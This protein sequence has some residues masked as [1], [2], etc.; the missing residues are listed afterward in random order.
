RE[1]ARLVGL[2]AAAE[3]LLVKFHVLLAARVLHARGDCDVGGFDRSF[4]ENRKFLEHE[5]EIWIGLQEIE[6]VSHGAPAETAIVVE[7][8]DHGDVA[9]RVAEDDLMR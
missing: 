1:R 7:E 4:A 8:L 5:L 6:H 9:L 2:A 3:K